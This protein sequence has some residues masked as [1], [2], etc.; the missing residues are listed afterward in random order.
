MLGRWM[1][2]S[3]RALAMGFPTFAQHADAAGTEVDETHVGPGA[4]SRVGNAMHVANVGTVAAVALACVA[5]CPR[6]H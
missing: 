6:G 5:K 4:A 1:L 3:E 2:A